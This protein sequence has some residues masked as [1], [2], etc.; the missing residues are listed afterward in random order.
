MFGAD[1]DTEGTIVAADADRQRV[2]TADSRTP[3]RV[4]TDVER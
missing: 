1:G 3:L 4:P 2:R